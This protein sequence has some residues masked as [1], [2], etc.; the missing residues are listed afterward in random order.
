MLNWFQETCKYLYILYH[1]SLL[2][3]VRYLKFC[4]MDEDHP[5]MRHSQYRGCWW[6]GNRRSQVIS[7]Y[8]TDL[9]CLEYLVFSIRQ[10]EKLSFKIE[11]F[12]TSRSTAVVGSVVPIPS[13]EK[14]NWKK[15]REVTSIAFAVIQWNIKQDLILDY[16]FIYP[17][18][19]YHIILP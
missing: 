14:N 19:P 13:T 8:G 3:L 2:R 16:N 1:V 9:V 5:F 12:L 4:F 15:N 6:L 11:G 7:S 10:I 18:F 17:I